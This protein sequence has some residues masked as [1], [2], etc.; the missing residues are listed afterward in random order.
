M[1]GRPKS[2]NRKKNTSL[3]IKIELDDILNEYLKD[4]SVTKSQYVEYLIKKEM[5]KIN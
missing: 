5:E 4:K 2:K 1:I 3:S